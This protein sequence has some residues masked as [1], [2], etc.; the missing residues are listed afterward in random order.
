MTIIRNFE[1]MRYKN[2]YEWLKNSKL[3]CTGKENSLM[4]RAWDAAVNGYPTESLIQSAVQ[5]ERERCATDIQNINNPYPE[6]VFPM[7]TKDY[8]KAIP[9]EHKRTTISGYCGRLFWDLAINEAVR[10]IRED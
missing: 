1:I 6:S 2:F 7:T 5:A 4:L 8:V 3:I 9:N 10:I